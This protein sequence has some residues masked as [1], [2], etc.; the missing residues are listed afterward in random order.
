MTYDVV[1]IFLVKN[2]IMPFCKFQ[3]VM[4]KM[5]G[6]MMMEVMTICVM[7]NTLHLHFCR[8]LAFSRIC[9]A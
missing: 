1:S 3:R 9:L 7:V 6:F 5:A 4:K 8:E 2:I